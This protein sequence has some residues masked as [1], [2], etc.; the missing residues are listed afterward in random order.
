MAIQRLDKKLL[1][2]IAEK[3]QR[4]RQ[5]INVMVSKKA[6]KLGISSEAALI[7]LAKELGIGTAV[8]QRKID[9]AKQAEVRDCL[10]II[11]VAKGRVKQGTNTKEKPIK[12]QQSRKVLLRAATD[13]LIRIR[14]E[15][16]KDRCQDLLLAS[17][18]F[19]RAINQATL[20]LEDRIRKKSLPPR[21]LEGVK[22]VNHA[23]NGDLSKTILKASNDPDEQ[24]GFADIFRGMML[25]F[26]NK[27]HHYVIDTFTRE[28]AL[29]IVS[30]ID[31]LL[32]AVDSSTKIR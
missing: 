11:L 13:Y 17:S 32:R 16:L 10:P 21:R 2:K 15:E 5:S 7:L 26:R 14:D 19:D 25:A 27:T 3:L 8:Y 9:G 4:K 31:V 18:K 12:S 1:D 6:S 23:F 29:R 24:Q 22:L 30:F 20:V 28:E